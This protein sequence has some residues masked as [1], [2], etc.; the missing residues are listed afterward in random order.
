VVLADF[1][2]GEGSLGTPGDARQAITVGAADASGKPMPPSACGLAFGL[3][4]LTKPTVLSPGVSA[5]DGPASGTSLSAGFAAGLAA[6][7]MSAGA[8]TEKFLRFLGTAPGGMLRVPD[9]WPG[10]RR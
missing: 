6:S 10:Q 7:A 3:E 4:L 5:G 1:A 8:P 9:Y 2:T